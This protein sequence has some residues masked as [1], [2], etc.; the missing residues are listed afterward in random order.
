MDL[1]LLIGRMLFVLTGA[2]WRPRV[3]VN[4]KVYM[5]IMDEPVPQ[6]SASEPK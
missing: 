5:W 1:N 3:H 6:D 2:I 4:G